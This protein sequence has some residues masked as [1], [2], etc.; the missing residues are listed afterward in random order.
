MD[1]QDERTQLEAV[2]KR[3][4]SRFGELPHELIVET[5]RASEA[6]LRQAVIRDFVPLLVEKE[7][8]DRLAALNK[9]LDHT[10][11]H[12]TSTA[13]TSHRHGHPQPQA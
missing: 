10:S 7:V 13:Q 2:A 12:R 9:Q 3:L 1:A 4:S 8:R 6:G 11:G 5:V